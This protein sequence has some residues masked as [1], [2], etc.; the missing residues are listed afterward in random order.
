MI[1]TNPSQP[2]PDQ[3]GNRNR[4]ENAHHLQLGETVSRLT[5]LYE[6]SLVHN[7]EVPINYFSSGGITPYFNSHDENC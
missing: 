4:E 6:R 5:H 1:R 2:S 7:V 3:T